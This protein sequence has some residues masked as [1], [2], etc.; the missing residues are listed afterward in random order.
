[1]HNVA[2]KPS[3]SSVSIMTIVIVIIIIIIIIIIWQKR[4][5]GMGKEEELDN[6]NYNWI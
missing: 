5:A 3:H 4:V 2:W 1:M 6:E